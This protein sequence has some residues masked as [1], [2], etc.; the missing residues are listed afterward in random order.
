MKYTLDILVDTRMLDCKPVDT[1]IDPNVKLVLG[2]G[3]L[4]RKRDIDNL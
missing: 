3:E 4:L 1:L 2:Q